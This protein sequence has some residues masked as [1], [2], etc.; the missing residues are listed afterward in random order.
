MC[1]LYLVALGDPKAAGSK[2]QGKIYRKMEM[3]REI[4]SNARRERQEGKA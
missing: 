1:P 2:I 3:T 4:V